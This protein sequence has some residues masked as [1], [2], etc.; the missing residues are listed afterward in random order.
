MTTLGCLWDD[1]LVEDMRREIVGRLDPLAQLLLALTSKGNYARYVPAQPKASE[2]VPTTMAEKLGAFAPVDFLAKHAPRFCRTKFSAERAY[3]WALWKANVSNVKWLRENAH[4]DTSNRTETRNLIAAARTGSI[5][6]MAYLLTD[7]ILEDSQK[8]DIDHYPLWMFSNHGP[9]HPPTWTIDAFNAA[10]R[11][12]AHIPLLEWL[13][14]KG[15][16]WV[17]GSAL[18]AA[19]ERDDMTTFRWLCAHFVPHCFGHEHTTSLPGA[20]M[21]AA[22]KKN[23]EAVLFFRSF[24]S[25]LTPTQWIL[26][27]WMYDKT[28]FDDASQF[29]QETWALLFPSSS[30]SSS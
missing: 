11:S 21:S 24:L 4:V 18:H 27:C 28:D 15:L 8:F 3:L 30:S 1:L 20:L 29:I 16:A 26:A 2:C 19:I 17:T 6:L 10:A 25:G 9:G 12:S 7:T 23:R 5:E 14:A 13:A 22:R